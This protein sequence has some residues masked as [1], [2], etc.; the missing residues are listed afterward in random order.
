MSNTTLAVFAE[1]FKSPS[2]GSILFMQFFS[3]SSSERERKGRREKGKKLLGR[4]RP[5]EGK[6]WRCTE[7]AEGESYSCYSC[8]S[9]RVDRETHRRK[10]DVPSVTATFRSCPVYPVYNPLHASPRLSQGDLNF[11]GAWARPDGAAL[12]ADLISPS[13]P[14][15]LCSATPSSAAAPPHPT[16]TLGTQNPRDNHISLCLS[17]S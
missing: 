13:T 16:A 6:Y 4:F 7:E 5:E 11:C 3:L 9:S 12:P 8:F 14:H 2:K 17:L 1:R 15:P 10:A